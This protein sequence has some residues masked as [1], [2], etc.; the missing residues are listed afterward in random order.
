MNRL[1]TVVLAL[2]MS[3]S[4]FA[5]GFGENLKITADRIKF[6]HQPMQGQNDLT[7]THKLINELSQD[8]EVLCKDKADKV[9]RSYSVH[10]WVSRYGHSNG[11]KVSFEVLFWVDDKTMPKDIK[12]LGTTTWFHLT[13]DTSLHALQLNQIVDNGL[14]SLELEVKAPHKD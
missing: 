11:P 3:A 5:A 13:E 7:C 10:L 1:V 6:V 14:S 9:K 4:S 12:T 8:W 2:V